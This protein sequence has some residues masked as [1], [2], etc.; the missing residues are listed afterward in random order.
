MIQIIDLEK[1]NFFAHVT[2]S[3]EV[4]F[5]DMAKLQMVHIFL[6]NEYFLTFKV[7]HSKRSQGRSCA[8]KCFGK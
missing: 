1:Q 7:L 2:A 6:L 3:Q 4:I 5:L 8:D